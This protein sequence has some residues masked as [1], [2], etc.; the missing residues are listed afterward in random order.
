MK[1]LVLGASMKSHR[2]SHKAV[3]RLVNYNHEVVA[4]GLKE[5]EING[6]NIDT[7]L[8]QYGDI[9]TVTLYLNPSVQPD[10]YE[11]ILSLQPERVIFN[12]GT[13]NSEFCATLKE[14]DIKCEVACTL[15]MLASNNY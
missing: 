3:D 7:E 13:E 2:F 14:K 5:G 15:V 9:H 10:Y 6:V 11:Y 4:F 12:P 1:T 8:V